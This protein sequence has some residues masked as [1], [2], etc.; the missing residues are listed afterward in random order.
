ML[1]R[2]NP[3]PIFYDEDEVKIPDIQ[4]FHQ[5]QHDIRVPHGEIVH[6]DQYRVVK[7]AEKLYRSGCNGDE[8]C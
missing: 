7:E 1:F 8:I 3:L 2:T 5:R 6:N 4:F